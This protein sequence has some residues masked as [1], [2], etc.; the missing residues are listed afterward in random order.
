MSGQ[1]IL[2]I[3]VSF[4]LFIV[5]GS[6]SINRIS[7]N[8]YDICG[9]NGSNIFILINCV[10]TVCLNEL[11]FTS[12]IWGWWCK[13]LDSTLS[14]TETFP[15]T[16]FWRQSRLLVFYSHSQSPI[17]PLSYA[18]HAA[19]SP[20]YVPLS[21]PCSHSHSY[22]V[23]NTTICSDQYSFV[24]SLHIYML[25]K[26]APSTSTSIHLL[27]FALIMS[28][29]KHHKEYKTTFCRVFCGFSS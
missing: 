3:F 11:K 7:N 27:I 16:M 19:N 6:Y 4:C 24:S 25:K 10:N 8:I 15:K 13:T 29:Y 21:L 18:R 26:S 2:Y 5:A 1:N 9:S 14:E 12:L 20:I 23:W 28:I 22:P 17:H